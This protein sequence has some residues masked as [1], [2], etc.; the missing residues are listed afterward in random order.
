LKVLAPQGQFTISPSAE[1][2]QHYLGFAAGSGITPIMGMIQEVM[3]VAPM[4][5]FTLVY[6]NQS[7]EEAMFLE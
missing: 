4:A 6:G 7:P 2:R 5:K 1:D 3:A